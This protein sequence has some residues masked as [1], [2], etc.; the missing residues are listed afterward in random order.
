MAGGQ[1]SSSTSSPT[2]Q[3]PMN[4]SNATSSLNVNKSS[5]SL[6]G[7]ALTFV[8]KHS[9]SLPQKTGNSRKT[10]LVAKSLSLPNYKDR[11]STRPSPIRKIRLSSAIFRVLR[12]RTPTKASEDD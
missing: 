4:S 12:P 10:T 1:T 5:N 3:C 7:S 2:Q 6:Q 9:N 8:S 11:S